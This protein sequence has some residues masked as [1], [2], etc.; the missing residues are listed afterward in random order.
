MQLSFFVILLFILQMNEDEIYSRKLESGLY[1]L[2]VCP[3]V[4]V[5]VIYPWEWLF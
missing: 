1:T 2:Q 4:T 3:V 5:S